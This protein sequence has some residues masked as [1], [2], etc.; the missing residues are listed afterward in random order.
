[1][2]ETTDREDL[3]ERAIEEAKELVLLL[4]RAKSERDVVIRDLAK[5][6]AAA[7]MLDGRTDLQAVGLI[8]GGQ[9]LPI[10]KAT[11]LLAEKIT[12]EFN[13][14]VGRVLMELGSARFHLQQVSPD[15]REKKWTL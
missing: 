14:E 5:M 2:N 7:A 6:G 10:H 11:A 13:T 1:M 4:K 12:K 15:W 8:S 9:I 3:L